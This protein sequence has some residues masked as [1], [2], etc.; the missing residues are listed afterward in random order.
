[1]PWSETVEMSRVKFISDL[2]I[3]RYDMTELCEKHGI[4]RKTGYKWATRFGREGVE[5]LKDRSCAP[6]HSPR[7]TRPEVAER[8]LELRRQH[9][10]WGPRKLLAWLEKHEPGPS[11]LRAMWVGGLLKRADL[12]G[13]CRRR[14][15]RARPVAVARTEASAANEVWTS[16]FKGEFRTGDG[17]LCYPLTM[18]D[19][20]SRFV[21]AI[22]GLPSV[23]GAGAWPVFERAFREYG[24]PRVIRTDNG[25]PFASSSALAGLSRLSVRW[26]KLGIVREKIEPGHPEQSARRGRMHRT[27]KAEPARPPA[28]NATG[29]QEL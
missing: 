24:L 5:G 11:W 8:L 14:V 29:Q 7:Q 22:Q 26:I 16:D 1:M 18:V 10:S 12:V 19:G 28:A 20:F 6:K 13:P 27:L 25:N 17:R 2:G 21:L 3:C 23:A 4:S 15:A 9:P